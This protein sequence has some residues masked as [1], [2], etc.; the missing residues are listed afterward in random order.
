MPF[1]Y[2]QYS[3]DRILLKYRTP[4]LRIMVR[5]VRGDARVY[6]ANLSKELIVNSEI[7]AQYAFRFK[8]F[9]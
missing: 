9:K 4:Y 7:N 3:T 2:K 5:Y 1:T 6:L 8:T